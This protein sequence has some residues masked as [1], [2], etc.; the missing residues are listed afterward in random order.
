MS[1]DVCILAGGHGRRLAGLWDSP[2][3]LVPYKGRPLIEELVNRALA[4][5]PRKIYLLLG[6]RASEV[7]AWREGCCPHRDVVLI[8]ETEPLGTAGALRN[9][10]PLLRA[11]V[12]VLNGDTLPGYDLSGLVQFH[13]RSWQPTATVA[14]CNNVHAGASVLSDRALSHIVNFYD[15]TDDLYAMLRGMS[16]RYD[17]S[18]FL[19]VGTPEGF[20]KVGR[21]T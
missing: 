2:K 16:L 11:P 6:H 21:K 4:L 18:E 7:V 8:I 19:D 15:E 14:W 9:V 12:L 13:E 5:R 10:A 3:C 17:V 20:H 1:L